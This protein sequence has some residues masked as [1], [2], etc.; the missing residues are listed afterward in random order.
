MVGRV[1]NR[2]FQTCRK[3]GLRALV[4]DATSYGSRLYQRQF[5]ER[6]YRRPM[7]HQLGGLSATLTPSE[8]FDFATNSP[9]A[10]LRPWQV[11]SEF[12]GLLDHV[13]VQ[14]KVRAYYARSVPH[15]YWMQPV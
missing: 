6:R 5:G 9:G 3:L 13:F 15:D 12:L 4:S 1:L 14:Q 2:A 7:M 11:R 10:L 8:V